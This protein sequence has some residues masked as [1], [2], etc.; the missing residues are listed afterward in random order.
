MKSFI[1]ICAMLVFFFSI[2]N[3]FSTEI[4]YPNIRFNSS[5]DHSNSTCIETALNQENLNSEMIYNYRFKQTFNGTTLDLNWGEGTWRS[6]Y[7]GSH[8]GTPPTSTQDFHPLARDTSRRIVAYIHAY[9]CNASI[10]QRLCATRIIKGLEYLCS[11][12]REDDTNNTDWNPARILCQLPNGHY[13]Y[14]GGHDNYQDVTNSVDYTK[15]VYETGLAARALYEGYYFIKNN[16]NLT[17]LNGNT[18][19]T[20]ELKYY[21][22]KALVKAGNAL[23][24]VNYSDYN[25]NYHC[26][27]I[28]GLCSAYKLTND[29]KYLNKAL[30]IFVELKEDYNQEDREVHNG[31]FNTEC[32]QSD[33]HCLWHNFNG[34]H[35]SYICYMGIIIRGLTE[36]YTTLPEGY[37]LGNV[38]RDNI[39]SIIIKSLNEIFDRIR[40]SSGPNPYILIPLTNTSEEAEYLDVNEF[41]TALCYT[42]SAGITQFEPTVFNLE[43]TFSFLITNMYNKY[44]STPVYEDQATQSTMFEGLEQYQH[45]MKLKQNSMPLEDLFPE[46]NSTEKPY[47]FKL[48]HYTK[49]T[50]LIDLYDLSQSTEI[51]GTSNAGTA[52]DMAVSGNFTRDA[53]LGEEMAYF[54]KLQMSD[55]HP[56]DLTLYDPF[57][58]NSGIYA[59]LSGSQASGARRLLS[60]DGLYLNPR[61]SYLMTSGDYDGDGTDELA[62]YMYDSENNNNYIQIYRLSGN[63][64]NPIYC[65]AT[66]YPDSPIIFISTPVFSQIAS[67]DFNNDGKD[68]VALYRGASINVLE[69]ITFSINDSSNW[70]M[71]HY[72]FHSGNVTL[73]GQILGMNRIDWNQDGTDDIIMFTHAI[74]R[75]VPLSQ[76]RNCKMYYTV[77]H[78]E[79]SLS[80]IYKLV[81]NKYINNL[82]WYPTYFA[83]GDF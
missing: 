14:H 22:P 40:I 9:E 28:W 52:F 50:K 54:R 48:A 25:A 67:G 2:T 74:L 72:P 33:D 45:L 19:D 36:L 43:S 1:S 39:K 6:G 77:F 4:I 3:G 20:S 30:Q 44:Y 23:L 47:N 61:W 34:Y 79:N 27:G 31:D 46:W 13:Y 80:S 7:W 51:S 29:T 42:A 58:N 63:S 38:N 68:E 81:D 5:L 56:C 70:L 53:Y 26:F 16:P 32:N 49:S 10:D 76:S 71:E 24:T 35:D 17:D 62:F 21:I 12:V 59:P 15:C 18:I 82:L 11:A 41:L 78:A 55:T 64:V 83:A 37:N 8:T 66:H 60:W 75:I 69:I 65:R 57:P 73:P